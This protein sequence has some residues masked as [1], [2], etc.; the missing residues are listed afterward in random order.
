MNSLSKA[1]RLPGWPVGLGLCVLGLA[2]VV[3]AVGLPDQQG[4]FRAAVDV[5]AVDVQVV[6]SKGLP[7]LKLGAGDF[8]VSIDG[9]RR[10]IVSA[11]FIQHT[12]AESSGGGVRAVSGPVATNS[13]PSTASPNGRTIMLGI[14]S[15][16]LSATTSREVMNA[17]RGFLAQLT[18]GDL[19]GIYAYPVGPRLVPTADHAAIARALDTI[20]GSNTPIRSEFHL[21]P[22]E[23]VDITAEAAATMP[24]SGVSTAGAARGATPDIA[25]P[26]ET[27]RRVQ[28]RESCMD[29]RCA[30]R[31]R[32]EATSAAF[33]LEARANQSV[34]GLRN[35]LQGMSL[36]PGRKTLVLLS[37]GM[38]VSDRPGGRPDV[39]GLERAMG[40]EVA[41]A[42]TAVYTVHFDSHYLSA[43]STENAR[44]ERMPVNRERDSSLIGRWLEMFSGASGGALLRV[45]VGSGETAFDRVLR[46]SSA[47]YLLGVEP[48]QSDRDGRTRQLRVK[49]NQRGVT[50]R[51]RTWIA[52]PK[53]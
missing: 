29:S 27:I 40:Q 10:R 41:L 12:S 30:T 48:E 5:I 52:L 8:E 43:F 11:D 3:G 17:A 34:D 16:S 14:D 23:V 4:T 26:S 15:G 46:E 28:Q 35:L 39:G 32:M 37:G 45:T 51:S 19:I 53:K 47:Y 18:A 6:D 7:I 13:L 20:I 49:V 2:A 31:I 1:R 24:T 33:E 50:L 38:V 44:G 22:S 9:R 42:N 21:R 36:L 25:S